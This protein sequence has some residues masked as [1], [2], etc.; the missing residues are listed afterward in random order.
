MHFD[1]I[2]AALT[3]RRVS[4]VSRLWRVMR[5]KWQARPERR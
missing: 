1:S 5:C 3:V 4:R 2:P